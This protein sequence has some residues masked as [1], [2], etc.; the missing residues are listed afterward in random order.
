[1]NIEKN[2]LSQQLGSTTTKVLGVMLVG[3]CIATCGYLGYQFGNQ[4]APAAHTAVSNGTNTTNT[5]VIAKPIVATNNQ[6]MGVAH[7]I[8]SGIPN[9]SMANVIM[10]DRAT[11]IITVP[12]Y[13]ASTNLSDSKAV[14]T[15]TIATTKTPTT[16]IV[17]TSPVIPA[18]ASI[19]TE[20]S[21]TNVPPPAVA[22]APVQTQ[23]A[24]AHTAVSDAIGDVSKPLAKKKFVWWK[25]ST[26]F[27]KSSK[28]AKSVASSNISATSA[29]VPSKT[30]H[31]K[32]PVKG[33][34]ALMGLA[35]QNSVAPAAKPEVKP[36]V[37]LDRIT[38]FAVDQEITPEM[39]KALNTYLQNYADK[40]AISTSAAFGKISQEV[41]QKLGDS[42]LKRVNS[43]HSAN[44]LAMHAYNHDGTLLTRMFTIIGLGHQPNAKG[45]NY[46]MMSKIYN[47]GIVN[48]KAESCRNFD[49]GSSNAPI[50]P[51]M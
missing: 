9:L 23:L 34:Q 39:Q 51:G 43:L 26:W 40:K 5:N 8:Y 30:L 31:A 19:A 22:S 21:T 11:Q 47:L 18:A 13:P 27:S 28:P 1:M 38:V 25:P 14:N 49:Q 36:S 41:A 33:G 16:D 20:A 24:P 48:F 32:E 3:A 7:E 46:K 29:S 2:R 15:A 44:V 12:C 37:P 4:P 42:D 50:N 6:Y 17:G 45:I 35:A 10:G